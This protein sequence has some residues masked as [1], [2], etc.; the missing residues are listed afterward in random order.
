MDVDVDV[1]VGV[2]VGVAVDVDVGVL[3]IRLTSLPLIAQRAMVL[4]NLR[5]DPKFESG[6]RRLFC[7]FMLVFG[8]A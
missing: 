5:E 7:P 2:G 6:F 8:L 1:D 4:E 3:I